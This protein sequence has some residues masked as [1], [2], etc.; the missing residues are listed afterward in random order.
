MTT[1]DKRIVQLEART[2]IEARRSLHIYCHDWDGPMIDKPERGA[3]MV[4]V[5]RCERCRNGNA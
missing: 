3:P 5:H 2:D 1:L 4:Q